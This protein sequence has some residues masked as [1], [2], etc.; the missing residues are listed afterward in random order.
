MRK[1]LLRQRILLLL[2]A[3]YCCAPLLGCTR[4]YTP[5]PAATLVRV[6]NTRACLVHVR[7]SPTIVIQNTRPICPL[8]NATGKRFYTYF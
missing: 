3:C 4:P 1:L 5:L 8:A 6:L 7:L 2:R